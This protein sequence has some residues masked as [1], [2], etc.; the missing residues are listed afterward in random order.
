M[1]QWTVAKGALKSTRGDVPK[2]YGIAAVVN[3]A[4]FAN[5][6]GCLCTHNKIAQVAYVHTTRSTFKVLETLKE[7]FFP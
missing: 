4:H 7:S 1:R 3:R 5:S 2:I 6:T